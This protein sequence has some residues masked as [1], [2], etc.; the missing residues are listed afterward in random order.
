[1]KPQYVL[2]PLVHLFAALSSVPSALGD[3]HRVPAQYATIQMGID[4][5]SVGDLVVI[6]SGIY[7]PFQIE[8]SNG[9]TLRGA[10]EVLIDA[11]GVASGITVE[12][13]SAVRLVGLE[14]RNAQVSGIDICSG[15]VSVE[16]CTILNSGRHGIQVVSGAGSRLER[17]WIG[18]S[19]VDGIHV[20]SD[21]VRVDRNTIEHSGAN[22]LTAVGSNCTISRN[23]ISESGTYGLQI[24]AAGEWVSDLLALKNQVDRSQV[25]GIMLLGAGQANSILENSISETDNTAIQVGHAGTILNGNRLKT[26]GRGILVLAP[27]CRLTNNRIKRAVVD[28]LILFSGADRSIVKNNQIKRSGDDGIEVFSSG[29]RFV[30]NQSRKSTD[31]DLV[32]HQAPGVNVY[33]KNRFG[34][35]SP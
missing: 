27:D 33:N 24:G 18:N 6:S 32:D 16:Q 30:R 34:T 15:S 26:V 7:A 23:L 28:G 3:T 4:A 29:N 10:G 22:G 31:F 5:A 19:T 13:S 8:N 20:Q 25:G 2:L 1:M 35:T 9:V 17:N 21:G 12:S 14:I 11:T